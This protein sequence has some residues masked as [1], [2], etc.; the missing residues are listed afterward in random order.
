MQQAL[1]SAPRQ[2]VQVA[3][4]ADLPAP[5][6][7]TPQQRQALPVLPMVPTQILQETA[8]LPQGPTQLDTAT[9]LVVAAPPQALP[10]PN[11]AG[12]PMMMSFPGGAMS[13]AAQAGGLS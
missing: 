12:L 2:V 3:S 8:Q 10:L 4:Q 7:V 9:P 5:Q 13:S 1:P 6:A 11:T